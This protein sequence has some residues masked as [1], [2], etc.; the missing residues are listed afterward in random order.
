MLTRLEVD[1]FK[2]LL[3]VEIDFGPFTCIAGANGM[4]KSNVFD[5]IEF[6]AALA[7]GTLT[8]AA[9]RV[10][11]ALGGRGNPLGLFWDGYREHGRVI[12]L[13]AE[14]LVPREVVDDLGSETRPTTTFL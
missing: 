12:R 5:V 2:N 3:D 1:G 14:M 7:D 6:L 10:R 9:A 13:A 4:G 11:G 8:E